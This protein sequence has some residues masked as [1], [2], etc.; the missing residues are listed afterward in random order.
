MDK[1]S[2]VGLSREHRPGRHGRPQCVTA[3]VPLSG[4]KAWHCDRSGCV[5]AASLSTLRAVCCGPGI[6]RSR[7]C[8]LCVQFLQRAPSSVCPK[9]PSLRTRR[10]ASWTLVAPCTR[11]PGTPFGSRPWLLNI[12]AFCFVHVQRRVRP[13]P[14]LRCAKEERCARPVLM[15]VWPRRLNLA[16]LLRR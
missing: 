4:C 11:F 9:N 16:I 15:V 6:P 8:F 13:H 5:P 10:S 7:A 2:D 1:L 14:G 12:V 3:S